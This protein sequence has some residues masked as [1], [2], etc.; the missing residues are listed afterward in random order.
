MYAENYL[1]RIGPGTT[2]AFFT[3]VFLSFFAKAV[4]EG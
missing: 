2:Q 3:S 1:Y 4:L